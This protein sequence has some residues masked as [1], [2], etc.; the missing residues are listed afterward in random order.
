MPKV[1]VIEKTVFEFSELSERAKDRARDWYRRGCCND[2]EPNFWEFEGCA[3]KL[4]IEFRP[5]PVRLM[6]GKTRNEPDI[7]YSVGDRG[8]Y[9]VFAGDWTYR[10]EAVAE[11]TADGWTDTTL[12][13]IAKELQRAWTLIQLSGGTTLTASMRTRSTGC[14]SMSMDIEVQSTS[15]L[16]GWRTTSSSQSPSP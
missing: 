11:I 10:P 5:R 13:D 6:S 16:R 7:N 3:K 4:G 12:L 9:C 2:W 8:E 15:L 14:S 1:I